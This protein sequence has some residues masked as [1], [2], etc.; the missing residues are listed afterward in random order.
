M[1]DARTGQDAAEAAIQQVAQ[2]DQVRFG[3]DFLARLRQHRKDDHES[4]SMALK[5][6]RL[7][8]QTW[9]PQVFS[10]RLK[11]C[12]ISFSSFSGHDAGPWIRFAPQAQH[13]PAPGIARAQ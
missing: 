9:H 4:I 5:A 13:P 10:E 12:K 8:R 2:T 7:S 6:R 1:R 11:R 3:K